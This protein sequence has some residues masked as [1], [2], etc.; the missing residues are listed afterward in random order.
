MMRAIL[1]CAGFGTRLQPLTYHTPKP[2]L[3]INGKPLIDYWL[4]TLFEAGIEKVLINTHYKSEQFVAHI[5]QSP[6]CNNIVVSYEE[7]IL[8]TAGTILENKSFLND[9][10]FLLIHADNLSLF[11]LSAFIQSHE[12]RPKDCEM[13]M[14]L[15]QTDVPQNCGVVELDDTIVTAFFEKVSNP[16]TCMANGAVYI[17]EYS[18]VDFIEKLQRKKIDFSLEVIPNFLGKIHTFLNDTYHRDIGTLESYGLSQ[19]EI[20]N[21]V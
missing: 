5:A 13:T 1:L 17:C 3:P 6:Y 18:I 16:P 20:R 2:L 14:M 21:F 11:S 4:D 19:I 10:P 15:F 7:E 8:N 9:E 12:N